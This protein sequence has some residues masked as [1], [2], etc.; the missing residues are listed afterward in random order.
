MAANVPFS[1]PGNFNF[2]NPDGW[3]KWKRRF[4]Q[5]VIAAGLD[6]AEDVRKVSVL[7]YCLGE[8][9]DDVLTSTNISDD[10]RK[11]YDVVVEKFDSFFRVR[12]NVIY[13]RAPTLLHG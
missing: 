11:K 5:Y 6:K 1:P 4:G 10:D 2:K 13:E 12:R 7:L 9:S 3:L 8:E